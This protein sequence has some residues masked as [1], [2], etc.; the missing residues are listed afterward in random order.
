MVTTQ[1][2]SPQF[3][4]SSINA[5]YNYWGPPGTIGTAA[6]KIRDQHDDPLLIRVD[7]D[8]VLESNTSLIEGIFNNI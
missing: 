4:I 5:K 8:P 2:E 7:Y 3:D 6:G 1:H